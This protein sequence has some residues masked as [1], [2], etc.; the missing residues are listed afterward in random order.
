MLVTESC[1]TLCDPMAYSLP[2]SS[3]HGILQ[4]RVLGY[5]AFTRGSFQ[6]R[7]QT[8][9]LLHGRQILTVWANTKLDSI[10]SGLYFYYYVSQSVSS[11]AQLCLTLCDPMSGSTPGLSVQHQLPEPTQTHVHWVGEGIRPSHPLLSPFPPALNLSQHQGLF[12]WVSS[13]H[14]VAKVLEFQLQ[15]Q[16]FQWKPRTD[17]L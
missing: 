3:I 12:K 7:D 5:I 14:Q 4:A 2:G 10:I 11:V 6:L 8:W 17:L 15:H 1:P 13:S 16:I 9:Y